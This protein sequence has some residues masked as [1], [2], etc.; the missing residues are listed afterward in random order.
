[1]KSVV[2]G[3]TIAGVALGVLLLVVIIISLFSRKSSRHSSH[4]FDEE[5]FSQQKSFS[6]ASQELS[7]DLRPDISRDYK[8]TNF[9]LI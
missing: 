6:L 2:S 5:K 3:L 4:F 1:M 9:V 8:G 7:K